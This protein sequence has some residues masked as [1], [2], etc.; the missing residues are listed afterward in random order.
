VSD[1]VISGRVD[2][3]APSARLQ[4]D[5]KREIG[6]HL[7]LA[8]GDV[9]ALPLARARTRWPS[10][11]QCVQAAADWTRSI[12]LKEVLTTSDIALMAT[13]G[14]KYHHDAEHYGGMAFCNLFLSE[15]C[16]LDVHFP[17]TGHRIPI[18]R[19]AVV[20][21]DTA[22][23]H[24]IVERGNRGLNGAGFSPDQDRTQIFLTWEL[25]IENTD[26]G[27]ALGIVLDTDPAAAL[28]L[29]EE[30]VWLNG[31]RVS[32]CPDSGRW[33]PTE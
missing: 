32:V 16:G 21:F 29:D 22:Q 31:A 6:L 24:T 2:V 20:I 8:P 11:N 19:G 1:T 9:E 4:A 13:L 30:Q 10:Y 3:P 14:T 15:D 18:V 25:P 5:W 17:A 33:R 23:P 28:G 26:V 12:G 7:D 27:R